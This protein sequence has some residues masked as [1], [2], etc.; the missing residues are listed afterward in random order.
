MAAGGWTGKLVPSFNLIGATTGESNHSS[1][2]SG[3][4]TTG[5]C[6]GSQYRKS[7]PYETASTPPGLTMV[8]P[9][10]P[11]SAVPRRLVSN[12]IVDPRESPGFDW[13]AI[14]V[15]LASER[16]AVVGARPQQGVAGGR[17]QGRPRM[18]R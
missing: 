5:S 10:D 7:P 3:F 4:N 11:Q 2:T 16:S 15:D 18:I 1:R 9:A 6:Y 17:C 12:R 14:T 13:Q 8:T